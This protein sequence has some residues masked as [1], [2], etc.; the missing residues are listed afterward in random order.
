MN[1]QYTGK[2][3]NTMKTESRAQNPISLPIFLRRYAAECRARCEVGAEDAI[4]VIP[5]IQLPRLER[6]EHHQRA[7][8]E[9]REQ[10]ERDRRPTAEGSGHDALQE[11]V[12]RED[13]G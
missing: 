11:R 9:H 7:D 4:V 13:V 1:I 3:A 5:L 8:Q 12:R 6:A 10:E 2:P